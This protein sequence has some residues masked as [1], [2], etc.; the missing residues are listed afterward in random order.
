M[1]VCRILCKLSFNLVLTSAVSESYKAWQAAITEEQ[2]PKLASAGT[3]SKSYIPPKDLRLSRTDKA[4]FH[5]AHEL[6]PSHDKVCN[7]EA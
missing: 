6:P 5:D 2:T 1:E 3:V 7:G 4:R